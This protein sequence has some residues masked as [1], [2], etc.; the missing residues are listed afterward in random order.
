MVS[1]VALEST[2]MIGPHWFSLVLRLV[3]DLVV[4]RI[5]LILLLLIPISTVPTIPGTRVDD[6]GPWDRPLIAML[7][8]TTVASAMMIYMRH[9]GLLI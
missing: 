2:S 6:R 3:G 5:L 9:D 1:G 4:T 8:V 7:N